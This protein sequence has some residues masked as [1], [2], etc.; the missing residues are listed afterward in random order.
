LRI[1]FSPVLFSISILSIIFGLVYDSNKAGAYVLLPKDCSSSIPKCVADDKLQFIFI[2]GE[3]KPEDKTVVTEIDRNWPSNR[4]FPPVYLESDGG[5]ALSAMAIGR[6]LRKRNAYVETSNPFNGDLEHYTPRCRS[7]CVSIAAGATRRQLEEI[8]LH[9]GSHVEMVG[10][11]VVSSVPL[12]PAEEEKERKYLEDMQIDPA[13]YETSKATPFTEMKYFNFMPN[14]AS[15]EQ[16]I[17]TWG[18]HMFDN[19]SITEK[20]WLPKRFTDEPSRLEELGFAVQHENYLASVDLAFWYASKAH[21]RKPEYSTALAV[22]EYAASKNDA[23]AMYTLGTVLIDGTWTKKSIREG[24]KWMLK[25]ARLGSP[26]AQNDL[27]WDYYKGHGVPKSIPL[28]VYWITRAAVSHEPY[29]YG[30]LC[31]MYG[32]GNVFKVEKFEAYKWCKLAVLN[33]PD[34]V[35]KKVSVNIFRRLNKSMSLQDI[36]TA[37]FIALKR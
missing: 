33:M 4:E 12:S 37:E 21:G 31:E 13:V 36:Q 7:A 20:N 17:V 8:G 16:K 10:G 22:L 27:G 11:E 25:A 32:A 26:A 24:H 3:I 1:N 2:F 28:A 19:P 15:N 30:S 9:S 23:N 6:I 35:D 5:S 18:F 14:V 29:A 34:G